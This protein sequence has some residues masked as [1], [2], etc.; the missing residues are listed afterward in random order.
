VFTEFCLLACA[1]LAKIFKFRLLASGAVKELIALFLH[2][3]EFLRQ[4]RSCGALLLR[5]CGFRAVAFGS[6]QLV[7]EVEVSAFEVGFSVSTGH[8]SPNNPDASDDAAIRVQCLVPSLRSGFR[9]RAPA[10]HPSTSEPG[11]LGT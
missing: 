8:R 9:L 2:A 10:P 4:P 11:V 7:V 1:A 3:L 5:N 6:G